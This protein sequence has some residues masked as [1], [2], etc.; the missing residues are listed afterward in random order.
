MT[1]R[2]RPRGLATLAVIVA[3]TGATLFARRHPQHRV[4]PPRGG[5]PVEFVPVAAP[6]DEESALVPLRPD[7]EQAV[8]DVAG[9]LTQLLLLSDRTLREVD[10]EFRDYYESDLR[11][12]A[13]EPWTAVSDEETL[14]VDFDLDERREIVVLGTWRDTF[15]NHGLRFVATLEPAWRLSEPYSYSLTTFQRVDMI[16][17]G[18]AVADLDGTRTPEIVLRLHD[19]PRCAARVISRF[20]RVWSVHTLPSMRQV[21][22]VQEGSRCVFVT[23]QSDVP[24]RFTW[25]PTGFSPLTP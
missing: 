14:E 3:A 8:R 23:Q 4:E 2:W 20:N 9:A 21:D 16:V 7:A 25:S 13:L 22:V 15:Y 6:C 12:R 17:D 24:R 10:P 18:F 19:G 11:P 1:W 5:R